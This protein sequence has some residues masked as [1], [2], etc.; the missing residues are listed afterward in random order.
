MNTT[1]RLITGIIAIV[2]GLFLVFAPFIWG[3]KEAWWMAWI[4]G[5]IVV[6]I[7]LFILFNNREDKIE[8]RKDK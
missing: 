5:V 7:G 4:Y 2:I 3:F 6:V 8:R 1:S